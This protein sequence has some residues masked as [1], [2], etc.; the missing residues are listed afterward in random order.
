MLGFVSYLNLRAMG[1]RPGSV[2]KNLLAFPRIPAQSAGVFPVDDQSEPV[3]AKTY[4]AKHS[5]FRQPDNL[6]DIGQI[7][8]SFHVFVVPRHDSPLVL[9]GDLSNC[10]LE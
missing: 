7:G 5:F 3:T 1:S 10:P 6:V 9:P 2:C 8:Y 4:S